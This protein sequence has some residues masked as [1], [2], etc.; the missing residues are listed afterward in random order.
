MTNFKHDVTLRCIVFL[1]SAHTDLYPRSFSRGKRGYTHARDDECVSRRGHDIGVYSGAGVKAACRLVVP[2]ARSRRSS[3]VS[4][5][6]VLR[7][8][9]G[10]SCLLCVP[11]VARREF[12]AAFERIGRF[13]EQSRTRTTAGSNQEEALGD[14]DMD[15]SSKGRAGAG[16]GAGSSTG[17]GAGT[18]ADPGASQDGTTGLGVGGSP[19]TTGAATAA[20]A[21]SGT[22]ASAVDTAGAMVG[23]VSELAANPTSALALACH[24]TML[25]CGAPGFVCRWRLLGWAPLPH[26]HNTVWA[27]CP[28]FVWTGSKDTDATGFATPIR[29]SCCVWNLVGHGL[30]WRFNPL[31]SLARLT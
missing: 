6:V 15:M 3:L 4:S 14:V 11:G 17:A 2:S 29:S 13:S 30:K 23:Q 18:G 25:S 31:V 7:R 22:V 8:C 10:S 9:L 27:C 28:G 5:C 24:L 16:A 19:A 1:R 12:E 21:A 26:N 20:A